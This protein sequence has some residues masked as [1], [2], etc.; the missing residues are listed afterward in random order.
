M[1][2]AAERW[3]DILSASLPTQSHRRRNALTGDWVLVSP[4]RTQRP[5]LGQHENTAP[6]IRPRYDPSCYLCPGNM[7]ANDMRN[8]AY[9]HTFV[10]ANDFPALEPA[11]ATA[12]VSQQAGPFAIE[13]VLGECRVIC[14]SPRHDLSFGELE[15]SDAVAVV[16]CWRHQFEELDGR[17]SNAYTLIFEN[18]GEAMGA[19][20][21]H[22]HGQLW[23]TSVLPNE[24]ERELRQ[25]TSYRR[26][27]GG[28]LLSDYL[29][30]EVSLGTR[31]VLMNEH[32]V[33]L[34]PH[35][36]AWPFELL[37]LPRR[38]LDSFS[39]MQPMEE[40]T[41]AALLRAVIGTYDRVFDAPFP[42]SMGWHPRPRGTGDEA[43][44]ILHAHFY[45]PLLRSAHI[46]KFQVGFE[47]LGMP[48]RDLTP[49]A[50]AARLRAVAGETL[51]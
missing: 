44:W 32:W 40:V 25:Q 19:S 8:P 33:A 31:I 42:Y 34:V 15:S 10:F 20:N 17:D 38:P 29:E 46:R 27:H 26:E 13:S 35:W 14:Y 47:M 30:A 7:R 39:G 18:R 45:P 51:P 50:A 43:G 11:T 4:H 6:A 28:A 37:I 2:T 1:S 36:A 5:W 3:I 22:P 9:E 12:S 49:E 41:L 21:P 24:I 48:Q 23:T 16:R